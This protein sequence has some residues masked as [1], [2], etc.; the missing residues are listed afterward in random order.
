MCQI[1]GVFV[2]VGGFVDRSGEGLWWSH[3]GV[4]N[5]GV[6]ELRDEPRDAVNA[7]CIGSCHNAVENSNN[8]P[9]DN[10]GIFVWVVE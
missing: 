6:G 10:D 8:I 1:A 9:A 3:A 2:L 5:D 4:L 7:A